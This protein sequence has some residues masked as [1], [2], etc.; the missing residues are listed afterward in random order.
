MKSF[1]RTMPIMGLFLL[2]ANAYAAPLKLTITCADLLSRLNA[3]G[4]VALTTGSVISLYP[5]AGIQASWIKVG[6][7]DRRV[8]TRVYFWTPGQSWSSYED[9]TPDQSGQ[10]EAPGVPDYSGGYG[11]GGD[12]FGVGGGVTGPNGGA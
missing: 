8:C 4:N 7:V 3:Y 1:F 11:G 5:Q 10:G 2:A 6:T 9:S 12:F